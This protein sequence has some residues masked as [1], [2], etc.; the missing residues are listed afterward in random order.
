MSDK[1]LVVNGKLVSDV[2]S[3]LNEHQDLEMFF[4]VVDGPLYSIMPNQFLGEIHRVHPSNWPLEEVKGKPYIE[5]RKVISCNQLDRRVKIQG[6][7]YQIRLA[8]IID[9]G[10][11]KRMVRYWQ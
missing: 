1:I 9:D 7:N 4:L 10:P 6:V 2:L 11:N 8:D 5:L 3:G